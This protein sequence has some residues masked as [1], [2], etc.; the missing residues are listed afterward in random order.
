MQKYSLYYQATVE[1][2]LCWFVVAAL[3][4]YDHLCFDR[5]ID[6]EKSIFEFFVPH[7]MEPLFLQVMHYFQQKGL[8]Y[9]LQKL[10]NRLINN[11]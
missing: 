5:T 11:T 6:A 4:T 9:N 7:D 8:V 10:P 3:K 1:R 2:T